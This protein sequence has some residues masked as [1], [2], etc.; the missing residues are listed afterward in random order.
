MN[1][2][3][4]FL[5]VL[6]L[7]TISLSPIYGQGK[8]KWSKVSKYELGLTECHFDKNAPAVVLH[9]SGSLYFSSG[10][11]Y[12]DKHYRIKILT[13]EGKNNYADNQL[14]TMPKIMKNK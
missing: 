10:N 14:L 7:L 9:S 11:V 3:A 5:I 13:E 6:F 12:I 8:L 4:L 2:K 1:K